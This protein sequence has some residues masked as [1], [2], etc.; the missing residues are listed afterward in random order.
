MVSPCHREALGEYLD[1]KK[2]NEEEQ[3][4]SYK[5]K[6]ESRLVRAGDIKSLSVVFTDGGGWEWVGGVGE[7]RG[8]AGGRAPPLLC[9]C[10]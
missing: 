4:K 9:C 7:G 3:S 10:L 8:R 5:Q 2:E 1:G 6:E